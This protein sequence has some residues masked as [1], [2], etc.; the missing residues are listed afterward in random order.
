M[1]FVKKLL[2]RLLIYQSLHLFWLI[3]DINYRKSHDFKY[4]LIF[5][6]N[7]TLTM[8]F[9]KRYWP[10][11]SHYWNVL[12]CKYIWILA[13]LETL[14]QSWWRW[15]QPSHI[16]QR[17]LPILKQNNSSLSL[18]YPSKQLFPSFHTIVDFEKIMFL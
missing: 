8:K 15:W 5:L 6:F 12:L 18:F 7:S 4:C 1:Y 13:S 10:L 16:S 17:L 3:E 14:S 2:M 11:L 9:F